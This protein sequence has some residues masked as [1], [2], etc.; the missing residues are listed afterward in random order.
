MSMKKVL[1]GIGMLAMVMGFCVAEPQSVYAAGTNQFESEENDSFETAT[2][3]E[4]GDSVTGVISENDDVDYYMLSAPANGKIEIDF[5]HVYA[6]SYASW[7]VYTYLYQDGRYIELSYNNIDLNSN[8]K[9][10]LPYIGAEQGGSYY[11][12]VEKYG[13]GVIGADYTIRTAFATSDYVEKE[14]NDVYAS[15]TNMKLNQIYQ[16]VIN[17]ID[18]KD[19][20]KIVAPENGKISLE[21][22]HTFADS[23]A[24]WDVYTYL[25][26]DGQY[27]ELSRYNID[28]NANEKVQLPYI[29]AV[30]NGIYYIKVERY[31]SGVV[32]ENYSIKTSFKASGYI[33]R[34][35]NDTYATATNMLV[36]HAYSGTIS[37]SDDK[38]FYKIVAPVDGRLNVAFQHEYEE[39]Y[40]GWNVYV[41]RYS[42][43]EYAELSSTTINLNADNKV[44]LPTIYI[45]KNGIYYVKVEKYGSGVVGK[46]YTLKPKFSTAAPYGLQIKQS[47]NT[48]KLTWAKATGADGYE[49]YYKTGQ[50]KSYKKLAT[51]KKASYSYK[52][53]V[54]GRTYYFKVRAYQKI[55]NKTYYSSFTTV[56]CVKK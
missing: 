27:I 50:S 4:S 43:G 13:S 6:D 16:G 25:Y 33:E 41:Y 34:E 18:D 54:K 17:N 45:R 3:I 26:Q 10:S 8:E 30:Q 51:T 42:N 23:Y 38:D 36:D 28:L 35:A 19:F 55:N 14:Q 44:S 7:N 24:S 12:K 39:S 11:I 21:F 47:K 37:N 20:F 2:V 48:A 52:K 29:G 9:V 22:R 1:A 15:A 31:G 5:C 46:D 53:L 32:G 56:K 40:S 49:I